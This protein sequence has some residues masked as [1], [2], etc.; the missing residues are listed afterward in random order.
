MAGQFVRR[1][2]LVDLIRCI[3][4]A[5]CTQRERSKRHAALVNI[6]GRP[7]MMADRDDP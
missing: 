3:G 2:A 5:P 7:E 1:G 4:Q 6:V